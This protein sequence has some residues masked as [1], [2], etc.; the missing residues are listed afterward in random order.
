MNKKTISTNTRKALWIGVFALTAGLAQAQVPRL[1]NP[2]VAGNGCRPGTVD[3]VA[4][5]DGQTISILFSDYIVEAGRDVN[6]RMDRKTCNIA[7]PVT[8]PQGYSLAI[9]QIDYRGFNSI[10]RGGNTQF[11]AE[12]FFAGARGPRFQRTFQGPLQDEYLVQNDVLAETVV[13]SNC[14]E[15]VILRANT[16]MVANTNARQEQVMATVDS[17]DV[18]A[19][20]IYHLQ[21]RRCGR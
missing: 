5:A 9:F 17:A 12:Y 19:A 21:W 13:W 7:I 10:P 4:S 6:R 11:T 14:G 15:Q 20:M 16:A 1:G 2:A 3:S 8:V 18:N